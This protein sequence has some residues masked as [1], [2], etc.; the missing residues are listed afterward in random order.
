MN[1]FAYHLGIDLHKRTSYW[2]LM[3]ND[4]QLLYQKNL[5]TSREGVL[6]A[7]R[8]IQIDPALMQAA[9]EPVSQWAWY[10]DILKE[11]GMT[12]HLANPYKAK[13]IAATRLKNDSSQGKVS[14]FFGKIV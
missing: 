13:L 14:H 3:D 11:H 6:R 1:K 9:V 8:D 10:G 7:L 5:P 4:Q 12:V 2:T